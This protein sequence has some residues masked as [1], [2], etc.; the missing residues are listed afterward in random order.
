MRGGGTM[1]RTDFRKSMGTALEEKLLTIVT[2]FFATSH[3]FNGIPSEELAKRVG[4]TWEEIRPAVAA[5][6][7]DRRIDAVFNTHQDNPTRQTISRPTVRRTNQ[8]ISNE[9]FLLLVPND[10]SNEI[11]EGK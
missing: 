10:R 6:I 3:D 4:S 1:C 8:P 7:R 5:L 2:D 9:R 11:G